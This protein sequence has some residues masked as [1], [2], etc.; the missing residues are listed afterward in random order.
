MTSRLIKVQKVLWKFK[1]S[2]DIILSFFTEERP[3]KIIQS[4]KFVL[5]SHT[6]QDINGFYYK[7]KVS[8]LF[9]ETV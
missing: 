7:C 2:T 1:K 8:L 4:D 6:S 3:I 9:I 5:L